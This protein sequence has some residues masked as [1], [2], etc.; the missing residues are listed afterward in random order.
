M[1]LRSILSGL[2]HKDREADAT[3]SKASQSTPSPLN[4]GITQERRAF[5][6]R[7]GDPVEVRLQSY[8]YTDPPC[9][10]KGWVRDRCPGG[11][12][13]TVEKPM[14]IGAWLRVRPTYVMEDVP[15]V[16]VLVKHCHPQGNRWVVGC[17]F[18]EPPPRELMLLFK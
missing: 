5:P 12:G 3:S 2:L 14:E 7:Y 11:L 6:R 13:L 17:Q 10:A 1:S 4:G 18:V 15:W 8:E 16:D 9:G